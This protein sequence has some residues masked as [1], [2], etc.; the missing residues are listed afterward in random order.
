M[1][2]SERNW[3][4]F[5]VLKP[6]AKK[7]KA[8]TYEPKFLKLWQTPLNYFGATWQEY[9][10]A[11]VGQSRDSDAL[12][13]SNFECML[14]E[15]GGESDTVHVV[16]ESHW[17]VGWIEWIAIH[18]DDIESLKI[19]DEIIENLAIYPVINDDHLT[20]IEYEEANQVWANCYTPKERVDYIR[21]NRDQ[22]EFSDFR[23]MLDCVRGKYF[24]GYASDL[25]Y[26]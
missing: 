6:P 9:Y 19:A 17:A 2:K 1:I 22:F 16:R 18:E 15:L 8:M 10:S 5:Y 25:I 24:A 21:M 14:I 4:L 11:G 12:E 7:G 13:R 26:G 23:D 20:A 3:R